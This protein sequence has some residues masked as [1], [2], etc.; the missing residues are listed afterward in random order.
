MLNFSALSSAF[1]FWIFATASMVVWG[2]S[3]E[4][5]LTQGSARAPVTG[6]RMVMAALVPALAV[7][8]LALAIPTVVLPY[9]ADSSLRDAVNAQQSFH[10]GAAT[11]FAR[12]AR[13]LNPQESVY[14]VEA[15]NIAFENGDW[16]TARD[17]YLDAAWLG[18]FDP[19][20]Y[21][22]LAVADSNLGLRAEAI[23][24][25]QHAVYLDPFDPI[26]QAILAQMTSGGS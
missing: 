9:L 20:V 4:V 11:L 7:P 14:A 6:S 10:P 17:A 25:A 16:P 23:A 21:R 22:D 5:R 2:A 19:R 24:A 18:T 1:P 3:R 12:N 8:A 13:A 26:N 15:G